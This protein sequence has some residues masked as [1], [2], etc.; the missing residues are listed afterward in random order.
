MIRQPM[1]LVVLLACVS[2]SAARSQQSDSARL[3]ELEK[4][5]E[6]LTRELERLRLG[7]DVA[8]SVDTSVLGFAPA[9]SKVYR[10]ARGVSLGGYGEVLYERFADTRQDGAPSGRTDQLDALRAVLYVGYKF[11]DRW[12][13]NSEIEVEHAATG[14]A[15]SVSMEFAYVD[16][17]PSD[18]FGLRA[19]LVLIPMG[20]VNELHE[21]TTFM[22]TERPETE[23][24]IIPTTWREG[25][26]GIF[27]EAGSFSYRAFLV[28]GLDGAGGGS[29]NAGGFSASGLR[30]GRQKGSKAV[31]EDLSVVGRVDFEAQP[32]LRVGAS[33]YVGESGQ[34]NPTGG[35]GGTI[36]ART[37]LTEGHVDW[38]F[39]GLSLRGLAALAFVDDVAELNAF[40]G[41]TGNESI[42]E[43][44]HGWYVEGSYDVLRSAT[45]NHQLRPVVRFEQ[46]NTQSRVPSG[47]SAD[48]ANDLDVLTFG[49]V[50][51]PITNLIFKAD[52]QVRSNG[53]RTESDQ[54]NLAVGYVF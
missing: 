33:G 11:D 30:G 7:E 21:P 47:F 1:M 5:V 17:R 35:V 15:G 51:K 23:R 40:R 41:L 2:F 52:Y 24:R 3:A 16:F 22:T 4:Q 42:G 27:G 14:Q 46:V 10:I 45:T 48:P 54:L 32:G 38:L 39:K 49:A 34:N 26:V 43:R 6:A 44:M 9:A 37:I 31:V 28:N 25:G 53:A 29:A 19:G 18:A 8:V 13:F 20:I 12:L 36:G 50:W